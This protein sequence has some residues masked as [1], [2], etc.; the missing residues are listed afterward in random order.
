VDNAAD[1]VILVDPHDQEMGTLDKLRAHQ[2]GLLH[3]AFSVFVFRDNRGVKELLIHQ[4]GANKYHSRLLWTNTC[5]SHPRVGEPLQAAAERRLQEEM[6]LK[7]PLTH[8]GH[9]IYRAACSDTLIEHEYDHVFTGLYDG[10]DF[11]P[12]PA[13]V[14]DWRWVSLPD[15]TRDLD[16]HPK[17]YSA[18][19][20]M[21]LSV[22][23]Q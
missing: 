14:E 9:F 2:L 21:A 12:H 19:L 15:L 5:C 13:E 6:G 11:K 4:R 23:I 1:H 16:Q 20:K 7:L 8:V 17:L 3:R 22:A 10:Q 18:W